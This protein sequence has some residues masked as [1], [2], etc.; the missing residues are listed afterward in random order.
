MYIGAWALKQLIHERKFKSQINKRLKVSW[1]KEKAQNLTETNA[2]F[3][4]WVLDIIQKSKFSSQ[5]KTLFVY[6]KCIC[7]LNENIWQ[8]LMQIV[9]ILTC[10]FSKRSTASL[11]WSLWANF[12]DSAPPHVHINWRLLLQAVNKTAEETAITRRRQKSYN[13]KD[14]R[15]SKSFRPKEH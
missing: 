2:S 9:N 15:C 12:L 14:N 7:D 5:T 10:I 6:I 11:R 3:N 4:N 1:G 8:Q 13:Y